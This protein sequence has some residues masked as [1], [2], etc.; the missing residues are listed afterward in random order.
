MA[1][2]GLTMTVSGLN[3]YRQM[4]AAVGLAGPPNSPPALGMADAMFAYMALYIEHVHR[5]LALALIAAA[6]L[7]SGH[8]AAARE[9]V[10]M[11]G[12]HV[13]VP[14]R[15]E[16]V[17]A[18]APP[19]SV[20]LMVAAP[21]TMTGVNLVP[22]ADA[23]RYPPAGVGGLPVLGGV[24]G[25]GRAA[26]PE[27]VLATRPQ[28]ALAWK[29]AMVDPAMVEGFFAKI[30]VPVVFIALD[31]LADW[32]AALRFTA[33]L[34]GRPGST[35]RQ[36]EYVERAMARV[37]AAVGPVPE[38]EQVRVYYAEGPAGLAT[39][40]HRSFHTEAIEL[41]G[42][43]NIHRCE[44]HS[45]MGMEAV[46]LETVM[47]GDPQVLIAQDPKFAAAVRSDSRWQA[48]RAV[49]EGQVLAVPQLPMNW[50]DRPPSVM[51]ALGIQWL[52]QRFYPARFQV[53]LRQETRAFYK[54]F[55]HVDLT[56]AD[57]DTLVPGR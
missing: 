28:V 41:A 54:L 13:T 24:Y 11:A 21:D 29:S 40:C 20:L 16:R 26:N 36:A 44:Q 3:E 50:L 53:D 56:E 17:W 19:L 32:P 35:Q 51:R 46:S 22:A 31:T 15:I 30:G 45:H 7:C 52:A 39:D 57:L 23:A 27:D 6:G 34:L 38:R 10:D 2:S 8:P 37:R 1:S 14:D 18:S 9:I 33:D 55:L 49:R 25:V 47:A 42:G 48:V 43:W 12:R 4:R 5:L